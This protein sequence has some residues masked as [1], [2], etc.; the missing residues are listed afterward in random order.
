MSSS[1]L[2][3]ILAMQR[4]L[5]GQLVEGN[6]AE[7]LVESLLKPRTK[8]GREIMA[9]ALTGRMRSDAALYR[10]AKRNAEEGTVVADA[11]LESA[12]GILEALGTMRAIAEKIAGPGYTPDAD[13]EK[14]FNGAKQTIASLVKNASYNGISFFDAS[15]WVGDERV[16]GT[17]ELRIQTGNS[18]KTITLTDLTAMSGAISG[19]GYQA[20][21]TTPGVG[22]VLKNKL[23]AFVKNMELHRSGFNALSA[24]F[25]SIAET[26]NRNAEI[27]DE[28]AS[29][30]ILGA[31]DDLL[32]R[33]LYAMLREQGGIVDKPS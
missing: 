17:G 30:S 27:N 21:A 25:S 32:G 19:W 7:S 33:L 20:L 1:N 29:R 13:D 18:Y 8:S 14:A 6:Q 22:E 28:A 31:R 2:S 23:D 4:E 9:E 5:I 15:Q 10:Q 16:S 12:D 26:L 3:T 11:L 24:G